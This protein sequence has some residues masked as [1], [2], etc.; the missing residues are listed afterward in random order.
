M[1]LNH[2]LLCDYFKVFNLTAS[3][4]QYIEKYSEVI[5]LLSMKLG[6]KF[7]SMKVVGAHHYTDQAWDVIRTAQNSLHSPSCISIVTVASLHRGPGAHLS[8]TGE[9]H[10]FQLTSC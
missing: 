3:T 2:Y 10:K 9:L 7:W 5:Y 8:K 6:R 1:T 4:Y